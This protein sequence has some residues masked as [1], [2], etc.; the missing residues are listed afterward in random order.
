[1]QNLRSVEQATPL[2]VREPVDDVLVLEDL[3]QRTP[4]VV[5]ANDVLGDSFFCRRALEEEGEEVSQRH[6]D[7]CILTP[8][9]RRDVPGRVAERVLDGVDDQ[10]NEER[11]VFWIERRPGALWTVGRAVNPHLRRVHEQRADDVIFEGYD[12]AEA[13]ERANDA[14]EDDV[15]VLEEDGG[16]ADVKPFTRKEVLPLLERFFFGR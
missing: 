4:A 7:D 2:L 14:L 12:L 13:L 10:G 16:A 11:V 6:R 8:V 5:L 15:R 3:S 1:L 9:K